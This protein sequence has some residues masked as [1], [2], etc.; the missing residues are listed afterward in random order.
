[1]RCAHDYS[2]MVIK[3][4]DTS[5]KKVGPMNI[6]EYKINPQFSGAL[7]ELDGDHGAMKNIAEDRIY[8]IT[9]GNGVF[10]IHG[11]EHKVSAK[12]MIFI[13]QNTPYNIIGRLS[14]LLIC[15]PEFQAEHDV[16]L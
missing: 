8:F 10:I 14:F 2:V 16:F 13:P 4:D 6:R 1:M 15:N 5:E 7:I 12:D 9:E 3:F 11:K